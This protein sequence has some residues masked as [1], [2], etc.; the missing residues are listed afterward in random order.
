LSAGEAFQRFHL[1]PTELHSRL[2]ALLD[3]APDLPVERRLRLAEKALALGWEDPALSLTASA[4]ALNA[5]G[6]DPWLAMVGQALAL[7][8]GAAALDGQELDVLQREFSRILLRAAAPRA[9]FSVPSLGDE[10]KEGNWE[11]VYA[12][13]KDKSHLPRVE[14]QQ[15]LLDWARQAQPRPPVPAFEPL[16]SKDGWLEALGVALG[17]L[18]SDACAE[19][20]EPLFTPTHVL[21][22]YRTL[23]ALDPE[24]HWDEA[25]GATLARRVRSGQRVQGTLTRSKGAFELRLRLT[26]EGKPAS[27]WKAKRFKLA[28]LQQAPGWMAAT[29]IGLCGRS[30]SKAN[31][32]VLAQ[33]AVRKGPQMLEFATALAGWDASLGPTERW[34]ALYAASPTPAVLRH[35]EF[36]RSADGKTRLELLDEVCKAEPWRVLLAGARVNA[37]KDDR[38]AFEAL[39]A[40]LELLKASPSEPAVLEKLQDCLWRLNFFGEME[41]ALRLGQRVSQGAPGQT[42][43]LVEHQTAW[44]WWYRGSDFANSVSPWGWDCVEL[45]IGQGLSL[46]AQGLLLH[47]KDLGLLERRLRLGSLT[48]SVSETQKAAWFEEARA[49]DPSLPGIYDARL[50]DLKAKWNGS[51]AQMLAFARQWKD[52]R[53]ELILQAHDQ[54]YHDDKDHFKKDPKAWEEVQNAML[55]HLRQQPYKLKIWRQYFW[56]AARAGHQEEAW[57]GLPKLLDS[58][59]AAKPFHDRIIVYAMY[60]IDEWA[61]KDKKD[62]VKDYIDQ[63]AVWSEVEAAYRRIG[64]A[65]PHN[66]SWLSDMA[67]RCWQHKRLA[68]GAWAAKRLGPGAWDDN[69]LWTEEELAKAK[70]WAAAEG[71]GMAPG[72][73]AATPA[74]QGKAL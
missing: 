35:A 62:R 54:L 31:A 7:S 63:D 8:G 38:R 12:E 15:A 64:E 47:P 46:T 43:L 48:R 1:R 32:R 41:E 45:G 36:N 29:V 58:I 21:G 37:L 74:P 70:A 30:L 57:K 4:Q 16:A 42:E 60:G 34:R 53:W 56:Q 27:P 33:P 23:G 44:A 5:A 24:A 73:Q 40:C 67:M 51:D 19:L 10:W 55:G 26:Q 59:P 52:A 3:R 2:P 18:A 13:R 11:G 20:P 14:V 68:P 28:Q 6:P 71:A 65:F 25:K 22:T 61:Q 49:V 50:E 17:L 72:V 39:D 69:Y 9:D 66:R